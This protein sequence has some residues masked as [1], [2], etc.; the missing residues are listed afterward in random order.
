MV[1][2]PS[3]CRTQDSGESSSD[4]QSH[5]PLLANT[6]NPYRPQQQGIEDRFEYDINRSQEDARRRSLNDDGYSTRPKLLP[7]SFSRYELDMDKSNPGLPEDTETKVQIFRPMPGVYVKPRPAKTVLKRGLQIPTRISYITSGFRLPR[8]LCDAGVDRAR[9]AAFTKEVTASGKMSKSQWATVVGCSCA[10]GLLV[11]CFLPPCGQ[12][13]FAPVFGHK[14][15][16]DKERENFRIALASGGLQLVTE[17]WN[18]I[19]FEPLGLQVLIEPPN[20]FGASNMATMDVASTKLFRYQEKNGLYSSTTGGLSE[21]ADKKE[22]KYARKEGKYR[23]KAARKGRVLIRPIQREPIQAEAES[24]AVNPNDYVGQL[25]G[26][27][28]SQ[29]KNGQENSGQ[30][31][32]FTSLPAAGPSKASQALD[33]CTAAMRLA[34]LG[35]GVDA[36]GSNI[37]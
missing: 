18:R 11:D 19:L 35:H 9:W 14:K 10:V 27:C 20:C 4:C 23:T 36:A 24:A 32:G 30:G 33:V 29:T 21:S 37:M 8:A 2:P 13:V 31:A 16:R 12:L 17:K 6:K 22:L 34:T 1:L 3:Y 7:T 25:D 26:G 15:R 28:K 5:I